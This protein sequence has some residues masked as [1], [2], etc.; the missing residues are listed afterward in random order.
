M[1]EKLNFINLP[2]ETEMAK[3]ILDIATCMYHQAEFAIIIQGF[4]FQTSLTSFKKLLT[5]I[6]EM[7]ITMSLPS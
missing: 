6:I 2:S 5:E 4:S 1:Q 3:W 7:S